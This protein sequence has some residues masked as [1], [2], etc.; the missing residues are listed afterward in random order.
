MRRVR[1]RTLYVSGIDATR[2]VLSTSCILLTFLMQFP[3]NPA[4]QSKTS[5]PWFTNLLGTV[6]L[7]TGKMGL[8]FRL[9]KNCAAIRI[10]HSRES[11]NPN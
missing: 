1:I 6:D 4:K 10:C 5:M 3:T 9:S 2:T 7:P 11:G 8:S